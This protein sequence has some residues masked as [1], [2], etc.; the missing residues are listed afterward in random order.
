MLQ[1]LDSDGQ[2]EGREDGTWDRIGDR[3]RSIEP[4]STSI[5]TLCRPNDFHKTVLN[6]SDPKVAVVNEMGFR[7][8]LRIGCPTLIELICKMMVDNVDTM[9]L[10]VS[11]HG[12]SF[13]LTRFKFTKIMGLAEGEYAVHLPPTISWTGKGW[14]QDVVCDND[15]RIL[16]SKLKETV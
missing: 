5:I 13:F 9:N 2:G 15:G 14:L 10:A 4:A 11:V 16:V 7:S 8:L 1:S 12:M 3:K 6:L